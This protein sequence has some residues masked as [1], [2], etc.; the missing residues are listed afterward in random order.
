MCISGRK[1]R[2]L[3]KDLLFSSVNVIV[4]LFVRH[5]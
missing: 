4:S 3:L 5:R 2:H 1:W